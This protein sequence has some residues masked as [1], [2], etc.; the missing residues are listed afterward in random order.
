MED[1]NTRIRVLEKITESHDRRIGEIEEFHR[2]VVDRFDQKIQLDA[3]NHVSMEKAVTK[4]V[5]TI[6]NLSDTMKATIDIASE[7]S[8]LSIKHEIIGQTIIKVATSLVVV[9]SAIWA[10]VKYLI[11]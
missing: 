11:A 7:A 5:T 9:I 2:S 3:A 10:V 6:E 4:A 8:K 1:H